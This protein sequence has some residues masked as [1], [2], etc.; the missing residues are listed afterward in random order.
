MKT[1]MNSIAFNARSTCV[2]SVLLLAFLALAGCSTALQQV[3]PS[4]YDF[5]PGALS[6]PTTPTTVAND[7]PA[8][9]T[10][11]I[12]GEINATA[13]LDSTAVQYRMAYT[14][15]LQLKPYS[16]A[17]W[18]M[19]PADLIRQ[20]LREQL[21]QSRTLLN[22]GEGGQSG[23]SAPNTLRVDLEEFSQLFESPDKSIGLLRMRVTLI[24]TQANG[25]TRA[26]QRSIIVQRP[27]PSADAAGGVRAL[28]DATDAAMQEVDDWLRGVMP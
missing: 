12:I 13:A 24:Q 5:G 17:R 23:L 14:D 28:T 3:R 26:A 7:K 20:R 11:L 9:S 16:K 10:P 27:A 21:G 22:P 2:I 6:T 15:A 19:A 18:S 4:V 1:H 25:A 8:P